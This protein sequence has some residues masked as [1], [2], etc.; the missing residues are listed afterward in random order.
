[1]SDDLRYRSKR[2][3]GQT[4]HKR[5]SNTSGSSG[6]IFGIWEEQRRMQ[7]EEDK[8]TRELTETKR[9]AKELSR[10]LRKHRY[11]EIKHES[12]S[13]FDSLTLFFISFYILSSRK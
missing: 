6:S 2:R 3:S 9:K 11:G 12:L 8:M 10:T 4:Q 5:E 7:S 13:K 1:M